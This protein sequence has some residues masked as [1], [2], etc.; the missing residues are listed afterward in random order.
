MT[1]R[2]WLCCAAAAGGASAVLAPATRAIAR[3]LNE[4]DWAQAT[5]SDA[6][7]AMRAKFAKEPIVRTPLADGLSLLAGPGGNVV[8]LSGSDGKVVVGTRDKFRTLKTGGKTLQETVA[9]KPTTEFDAVWGKRFMPADL[10]VTIV[11]QTL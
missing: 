8:V 7:N 5:T 4:N 3:V 11:Y 2:E 9:A 6:V 1:R 10:Y